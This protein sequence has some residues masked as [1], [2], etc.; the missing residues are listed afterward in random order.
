MNKRGVGVIFCL[1][2]IILFSTRYITTAIFLSG[3]TSWDA[4]TFVMG[5]SYVGSEL[6]YLSIISL[7]IGIVYLILG[8]IEEKKNNNKN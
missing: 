1:M 7:I 4:E 6:L 2:A 3:V 5:L 8:E